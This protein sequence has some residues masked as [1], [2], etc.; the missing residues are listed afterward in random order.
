MI[1]TRD[2]TALP[3]IEPLRR[4]CQS[5]AVLDAVLEPGWEYRYYSF[6]SRWA[7]GEQMAS[8]RNGQGDDYFILFEERGTALKGFAHEAPMAGPSPGGR[9]PWPGVLDRVPEDFQRFLDEPAFDLA[10][11]TFCVWRR[12]RDHTWKVGPIDFP[13]GD[14]PDGS[15]GLLSILDG[16]PRSYQRWA[17]HYYERK[18][19]LRGVRAVYGHAPLTEALVRGLNPDRSPADLAEDVAEIGYPSAP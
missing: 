9:H 4:L 10:Y 5:L 15:A 3:A 17:R 11:T 2:L 16:D 8:M 12:R 14:D 7:P 6:N 1:S 13:P 18:V 19:P